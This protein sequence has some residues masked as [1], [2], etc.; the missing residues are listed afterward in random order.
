M[1]NHVKHKII[2]EGIG[3]LYPKRFDF[4]EFIPMP[5][6][7]KQSGFDDDIEYNAVKIAK[8]IIK[9]EKALQEIMKRVAFRAN[10]IGL[11]IYSERMLSD[12][13]KIVADYIN[14]NKEY[15]NVSISMVKSKLVN[16][17]YSV[18]T[19]G[20]I[21]WYG[22]CNRYWNT[23]WNSF[24][25]MVEDDN[26]I[27]FSTAWSTPIPVFKKMFEKYKDKAIEIYLAD[28]LIPD[29]SGRYYKEKDTS[30][31]TLTW[32]KNKEEASKF[33]KIAWGY[34]PYKDEEDTVEID[35]AKNTNHIHYIPD[36]RKMFKDAKPINIKIVHPEDKS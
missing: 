15:K 5:D 9:D 27:T 31:Y 28:E 16:M 23:K 26:T 25:L 24:D 7:I 2:M 4:N 33:A 13:D 34:D 12:F 10:Q 20:C 21:D 22:W 32:A 18:L 14:N 6:C 17:I 3:E 36:Y 1:P 29:N 30:E 11:N 19:T 35:I 8:D